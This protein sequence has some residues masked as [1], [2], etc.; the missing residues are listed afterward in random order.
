MAKRQMTIAAPVRAPEFLTLAE[1]MADASG[2]VLRR[3]FRKD[4]RFDDKADLT[5]VTAA[6]REVE[7]LLRG[8]IEAEHPDHGIVGEEFG[9]VRE[10]A[11]T[12]WVLDPID[13]TGGFVTGKPLFGTLIGCLHKG[14]PIAGVIDHPALRERWVGGEGVPTTFNGQ[15]VRARP[16][17][18]IADAMLYATTPHMFVG[19]DAYAFDALCEAVK[20]PQYGADCYAY[21]LLASGFVDLVVEASMKPSDYCALA[22]VVEAAGGII[23][24]WAGRPLGLKSDGRVIAAGD[25]RIHA[26]ALKI[27]SAGRDFGGLG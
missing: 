11:D 15:R 9:A 25:A 21:G 10:D 27:L 23:T 5:P 22:P 4:L 3:Y 14:V 17:A 13:G 1:R 8:M 18:R 26:R 20:R 19:G 24:D 16:C 2:E 6:D 12:V 7:T